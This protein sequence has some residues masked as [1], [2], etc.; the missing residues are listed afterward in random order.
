LAAK[1]GVQN[2]LFLLVSD[3]QAPRVI[4]FNARFSF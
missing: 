2:P 4:R 1:A 3:Y